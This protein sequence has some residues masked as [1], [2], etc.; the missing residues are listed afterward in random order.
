L[1]R[2]AGQRFF[3][4]IASNFTAELGLKTVVVTHLLPGRRMFLDG[5]A[6][7]CP[8][9]TVLPKPKSIGSAALQQVREIY[10]CAR[11][12]RRTFTDPKKALEYFESRYPGES[13]ILL[14]V[15]GYFAP[16]IASLNTNFSGRI[17]GVVE[18]TENGFQKYARQPILSCPVFSV[19]RSPLKIPEDYLVGQSI[20]F[21]IEALLREQGDVLQGRSVCVIGYGK[22]GASVAG[23][24]HNRAAQVTIF[25]SNPIKRTEALA[26][27]FHVTKDKESSIRGA[28]VVICATGNLSLQESDFGSIAPGAYVASV[29]SSDDELDISGLRMTYRRQY[30]SEYIDRFRNANHY[31]YLMNHGNAVNFI[32]GASVGPF[33]YLVQAEIIAA[34]S[35][36]SAGAPPG[37]NEVGDSARAKIAECWL[38]EFSEGAT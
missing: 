17:V 38:E 20:V 37:L 31:F 21:S 34:I 9:A 15:G 13:L 24:L 29:T 5:V 32:H 36:I 8:I 33:I 6:A 2:S 4:A 22:V 14:D 30:V 25:D 19:A 35:A 27:G 1:S 12:D 7:V 16:I 10:A 11:L 28:G 23:L 3:D 26:H 18:D